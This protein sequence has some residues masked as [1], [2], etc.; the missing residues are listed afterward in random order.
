MHYF[1]Y[2]HK[3]K[4]D[5]NE[6]LNYLVEGIIYKIQEWC[7]LAENNSFCRTIPFNHEPNFFPLEPFKLSQ[8]QV[9]KYNN[10]FLISNDSFIESVRRPYVH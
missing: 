2:F 3:V 5:Q 7:E 10:F 1:L 9:Q 6:I 4:K 8:Q